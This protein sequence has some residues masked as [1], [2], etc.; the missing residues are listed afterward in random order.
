MVE[1]KRIWIYERFYYGNV[2]C[3]KIT[4]LQAQNCKTGHYIPIMPDELVKEMVL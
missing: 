3:Q 4:E 2:L 1:F